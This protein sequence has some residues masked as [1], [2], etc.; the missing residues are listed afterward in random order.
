MTTYAQ[1]ESIHDQL[2]DAFGADAKAARPEERVPVLIPRS[3]LKAAVRATS[4][5]AVTATEAVNITVDLGIA[6]LD[7]ATLEMLLGTEPKRRRP[8]TQAEGNQ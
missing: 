6:A 2:T 7:A 4:S 3:R 8:A 1:N 5:F